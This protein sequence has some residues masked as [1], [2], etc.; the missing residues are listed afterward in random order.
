MLIENKTERKLDRQI[1]KQLPDNI[2]GLL[3][4][5]LPVGVGGQLKAQADQGSPDLDKCVYDKS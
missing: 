5:G 3:G 1:E 4:E 2:Y